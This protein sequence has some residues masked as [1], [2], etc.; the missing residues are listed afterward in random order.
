VTLECHSN[1]LFSRAYPAQTSRTPTE[2]SRRDID[3]TN[4][5][6]KRGTRQ[7]AQA[8]TH[9]TQTRSVAVGAMHVLALFQGN[10][11]C[12]HAWETVACGRWR[13]S[14]HSLP[15]IEFRSA[16]S[17]L[18]GDDAV[19]DTAH[20]CGWSGGRLAGWRHANAVVW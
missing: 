6:D 9:K 10:T 16:G 14:A 4:R 11:T 20:P 3:R 5:R 15:R 18:F 8:Q 13:V 17:V 12:M 2:S 19:N 1:I 7:Q